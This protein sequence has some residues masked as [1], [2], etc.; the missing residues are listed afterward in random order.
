MAQFCSQHRKENMVSIRSK[1]CTEQGCTKQQP[2]YG[3]IEGTIINNRTAEF[4]VQHSGRMGWSARRAALNEVA[5]IR[6][7]TE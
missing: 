6:R 3:V 4:C 7:A 2:E 1:R 5:P